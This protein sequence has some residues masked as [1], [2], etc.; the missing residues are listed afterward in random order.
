MELASRYQQI[1]RLIHQKA[2]LLTQAKLVAPGRI[3]RF[4]NPHV[5]R[6]VRPTCTAYE[7]ASYSGG[8]V[9]D[10][11]A[12]G[13]TELTLDTLEPVGALTVGSIGDLQVTSGNVQD[14]TL[15]LQ[16]EL[17][18]DLTA[19]SE[20]VLSTYSV[21]VDG[22]YPRLAQQLVLLSKLPIVPGDQL[23]HLGQLYNVIGA[24]FAGNIQ[25][26]M[27][28]WDVTLDS[29][30]QDAV[31][32]QSLMFL[33]ATAALHWKDVAVPDFPCLLSL[34]IATHLTDD[35][36]LGYSFIRLMSGDI[37]QQTCYGVNAIRLSRI[38]IAPRAWRF[39]NIQQ[40]YITFTG[41]TCKMHPV[42]G[43]LF[44][45]LGFLDQLDSSQFSHWTLSVQ[46]SAPGKLVVT[47][48]TTHEF[49]LVTGLQ[50]ITVPSPGTLL[51]N[52]QVASDVP[53]CLGALI[54][55]NEIT[56]VDLSLMVANQ[57]KLGSHILG[58]PSFMTLLHDPALTWAKVNRSSCNSGFTVKPTLTTRR[59]SQ[60]PEVK[61]QTLTLYPS[62]PAFAPG[63]VVQF[64]CA[65]SSYPE[66]LVWEASAGAITQEGLW[67]APLSSMSGVTITAKLAS[68]S[69][70]STSIAFDLKQNVATV[71]T[72]YT[73]AS[74]LT[75]SGP[76]KA[77]FGVA[78]QGS[79]EA[80]TWEMLQGPQGISTAIEST[81]AVSVTVPQN[82][83]L[84]ASFA[85]FRIRLVADPTSYADMMLWFPA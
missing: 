70:I 59:L 39:A 45:D 49:P 83:H 53:I 27:Q 80:F 26:G 37:C 13:S 11:H 43:L 33:Q 68:N 55:D 48:G 81:T 22:S 21:E 1:E 42:D 71:P 85:T 23:G 12:K 15:L 51:G 35:K 50:T 36:A 17:S 74:S 56:A 24:T 20:Y 57:Q 28:Q 77:E 18:R 62:Y 63:S 25:N 5:R 73:L 7:Y 9:H 8:L 78:F 29:P 72:E 69:Q 54:P 64:F 14:S 61:R 79:P 10:D 58:N 44:A 46:A 65:F 84:L 30:L 4:P 6:L 3:Q 41:S 47:A 67:T 16:T 31:E 32:E 76:Y 2:F 66:P 60:P 75:N 82:V 40:G 38:A 34:P 52:L 19:K